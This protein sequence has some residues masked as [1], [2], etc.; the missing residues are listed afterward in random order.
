MRIHSLILTTL[1]LYEL[2]T[3]DQFQSGRI[4]D[5]RRRERANIFRRLNAMPPNRP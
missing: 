1:D 5:H 3:L 2:F 4:V